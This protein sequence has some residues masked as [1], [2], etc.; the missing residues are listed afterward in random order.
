MSRVM[1]SRLVPAALSTA[2]HS[3]SGAFAMPFW[4]L[5]LPLTFAFA[6][7]LPLL[8]PLALA[9]APAPVRALAFALLAWPLA[10]AALASSLALALLAA[11]GCASRPFLEPTPSLPR[12]ASM[13]RMA[14]PATSALRSFTWSPLRSRKQT[15]AGSPW[16]TAASM[17]AQ[18][19]AHTNLGPPADRC[20]SVAIMSSSCASQ[21]GASAQSSKN[22]LRHM[23]A[24]RA[25]AER[26]ERAAWETCGSASAR[27][28]S[29]SARLQ[30][31][32]A[33][34]RKLMMASCW[35]AQSSSLAELPVTSASRSSTMAA[36]SPPTA[37][38][39]ARSGTGST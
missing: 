5:G 10:R 8:C 34:R 24:L 30:S 2:V 20:S 23:S 16:R 28:C 14:L 27:F 33:R 18:D 37:K 26:S 19:A 9:P 22:S 31:S 32:L 17:A 29:S 39:S 25:M 11:P 13:Q 1:S 38:R 21:A 12:Q 35:S 36:A 6:L 4:A 7:A 3:G 15:R